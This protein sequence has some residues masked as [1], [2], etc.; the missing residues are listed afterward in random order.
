[1][2][3][4]VTTVDSYRD[5]SR[6]AADIVLAGV[7]LN[8]QTTLGLAAGETP[9]GLYRE[10]VRCERAG[11]ISFAGVR[12]FALDEYV[13]LAA[14]DGASFRHFLETH[15]FSQTSFRAENIHG[16]DGGA[17]DLDAECARY[18]EAIEACGGIDLDILGIGLNGHLGFNE[19]GSNFES[20]T[21]VV[22]LAE[23]TRVA[24]ASH[25]GGL[26]HVPRRALTR[27]LGTILRS[28]KI[29]LLA[30][31]REKAAIVAEA[32]HGT[33]NPNLPA[34]ALQSHPAVAVFLSRAPPEPTDLLP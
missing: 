34:S 30:C 26:A 7:R 25:F 23:S 22:E 2:E 9:V 27:G 10:L 20:A 24:N 1:M 33:P 13:G 31:G 11:T 14:G 16:L 29:L 6:L 17:A 3:I 21:R 28:R 12:A 4:P 15:L 18:E 19:P 32:L 5:L 8:P